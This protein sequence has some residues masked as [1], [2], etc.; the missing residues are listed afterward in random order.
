MAEL[1]VRDLS[2]AAVGAWTRTDLANATEEPPSP[3]EA[4]EFH[5]CYC[6][7]ASFKGSPPWERHDAGDELLHILAGSSRLTLRSEA[8]EIVRDLHAGDMAVIPRGRWHRNDA[9]DGVT[10]LFMTPASGNQHS[11]EDPAAP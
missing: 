6:A 10:V 2:P 3:I 9:P 8:G 11:W 5:G 4:F 7:V 1:Y